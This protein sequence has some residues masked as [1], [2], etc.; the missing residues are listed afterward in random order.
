MK[1]TFRQWWSTIP[2][3]STKK[4]ITSPLI[5]YPQVI[6][7]MVRVKWVSQAS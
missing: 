3:I 4:T 2:S 6:R 5:W 1:K 7:A